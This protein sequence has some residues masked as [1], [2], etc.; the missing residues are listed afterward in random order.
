V[1]APPPTRVPLEQPRPLDETERG[2]LDFLLAGP[3]GRPELREQALSAQ[4][5]GRC[6]CGCPSVYLTV[7][8][9]APTLVIDVSES[10]T[11]DPSYYSLTASGRNVDGEDVQVTL[12]VVDGWLEEL[13]LFAGREG[14]AQLP[15]RST[16]RHSTDA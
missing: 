2:L 4:A 9:H 11:R 14:P 5:I 13:E 1:D 8:R 7:D 10:P 3:R 6:S 12:H 15:P 16:L